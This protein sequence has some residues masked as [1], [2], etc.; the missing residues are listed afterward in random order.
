V[1]WDGTLKSR[2]FCDGSV[3]KGRDLLYSL[4]YTSCISQPGMRI[5]WAIVAIRGWV[6]VGA[7]AINAFAQADP[8]KEPTFVRIGDQMAE[9]MEDINGTQPDR[10]QV[11][12]VLCALQGHP[13]AGSS[14]ADK[15]EDLLI[16][17]M[18]FTSTTHETC[19]YIGSYDGQDIMICRQKDN[20]LAAG[21]LESPIRQL[22]QFLGTKINIEADI[23]LVSHYNGIEIVQDQDYIKIHVGKYIGKILANHG[24]EQWSKA[25][26][27]LIEPLHPSAFK[28]LEETAPLTSPAEKAELERSAGFAYRNAKCE[29]LYAFVT[30]RLDIGYA[31][32]EMSKFFSA[33]AACHYAATKRVYRYLCQTQEEGLVYWRPRPRDDLPHVPLVCRSVDEIDLK[34][35]YPT[36]I[37]QL[38]AYFDVAHA[39]CSKTR[40]SLGAKVF[41]LA[42]AEIYYRAKWIIVIC[43]SSTEAEFVVCVRAGKSARY[44]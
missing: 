9:W 34:L 2:S 40:R 3:L 17:Q 19:L 14:W 20:F 43:T 37:D 31:M 36:E 33:P 8:P 42:G 7:D 32:A 30:C 16:T 44:I 38:A 15:V 28:E 6:A 21:E 18:S 35:P 1:K 22:F 23:G 4:H 12:Q 41:C 24:W 11:L 39:N 5:F 29:F 26:S 25:E 13:A 27:R 10:S